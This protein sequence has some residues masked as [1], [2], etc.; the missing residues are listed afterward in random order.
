MKTITSSV[1]TVQCGLD[2]FFKGMTEIDRDGGKITGKSDGKNFTLEGEVFRWD[3]ISSHVR[4]NG[5]NYAIIWWYDTE[6]KLRYARPS[7]ETIKILLEEAE[8]T[9]QTRP[10]YKGFRLPRR[11]ESV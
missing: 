5:R 2:R 3:K 10:T 9:G 8:V 6:G 1:T 11:A 4:R 7:I